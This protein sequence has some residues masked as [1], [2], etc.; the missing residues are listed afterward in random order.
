MKKHQVIVVVGDT[1]S[2]KTTQLP[3]MALEYVATLPENQRRLVGCTQPRRIAAAS[4]AKRVAE[5]LHVE[6]GDEVGYQVRFEDKSS[7]STQLKFMTD[8]ILLAETQRDREL[9]HYS[10]LIID[11]A[12]ERSLN[13]DF[14]LGYLNRLVEIRPDLRVLISSATLD[15]GAFADFFNGAPVIE[16]EGRTFPVETHY[17][18]PVRQNMELPQQVVEACEWIKS[19]DNEGDVLVFLP[20]EREIRESAEVLE[21]MRWGRTEVLPLYARLSLQQQQ[22]VFRTLNGT[23]RIVLATNVAETSLTIP[24]IVY[25]IDSGLA[26]VS[27]WNPSRQVQRLQIEPVSQASAR[28]RKGRCGRLKEG[29]CVRLYEEEDHDGRVEYTDPE[30][31]RSSLAGVIL[32]M[33]SLKLPKI[34]EFPFLDPPSSKHVSEGYRTLREI[35]ALSEDHKLTEVGRNLSRLPTEPR[36]GKMLLEASQFG[37]LAE[38]LVIVSGLSIMDPRERPQGKEPQA[39]Q[40]QAKWKHKD[41]D[42]LSLLLLWLSINQCRQGKHLQ[43]NQLRKVCKAGFLNF[44]RVIEWDNLL[45]ELTRLCKGALKLELKPLADNFESFTHPDTIHKAI[46]SGIP[47][48]VG[49]YD[50][51]KRSYRGAQGRE[52]SIFPGSHLFSKKKLEWVL[53]YE[54]VETSRLWSRRNA[55][56]NPE[57]VEEV[58][59][60][61]CKKRW[62]SAYYDEAQ[63]AVY[64]RE[65][66]SLGNLPLVENR[67]VHFG[68][69][70]EKASLEIFIREAILLDKLKSKPPIIKHLQF[71]REQVEGLE[72]K[73]RRVDG[74]WSDELLV[75]WF[76][77]HLPADC[78]TAKKFITWA[79]STQVALTL[80]DTTYEEVEN[81]HIDDFPDE[82]T[83]AD[84]CYPLYYKVAPSEVDD[85]I[86]VG[87]HV[88][89][90]SVFSNDL[91]EWGVQGDLVERTQLL[92]RSLPKVQRI[93]CNPARETAEQFAE[94]MRAVERKES[95]FIMLARF[96]SERT[97]QRMDADGFDPEKL[98]SS[99]KM[100]IW[101]CD[102]DGQELDFGTDIIQLKKKLAKLT[103]QR[104]EDSTSSEWNYTGLTGF[105][106]EALPVHIEKPQG[107]AYPALIDEGQ[108]V[109]V[110]VYA[111]VIEAASQH[112]RGVIRLFL[113]QHID[114]AK[115]LSKNLPLSIEAK[116]YLPLLGEGGVDQTA[117]LRWVIEHAMGENLARTAEDFSKAADRARG[118]LFD[119]AGKVCRLL[120][121]IVSLQR[122]V[123]SILVG[124]RHD[125]NLAEIAEDIDEQI[126]WILRSGFSRQ[127]NV[128]QLHSYKIWFEGMLQRIGRATSQALIKDLEKM[129]LILEFWSPWYERWLERKSDYPLIELGRMMNH[130]RT[131]VF[132]PAIKLPE[133]ISQKV[134]RQR[135]EELGLM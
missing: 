40:A 32:R 54:I 71:L 48:Q 111:C 134:V 23:Q 53:A 45:S 113:L 107:F 100:K 21:G 57:W 103:K 17:L 36:M 94:G 76:H 98:P 63:G 47:K 26:R 64:A 4:V 31:R 133:K 117:V 128:W 131:S 46:L 77:K 33:K 119:S 89:Q 120:D 41:S 61:L 123:E 15:S 135:M 105:D 27:R 104:F 124:W 58:A 18:P 74:I 95:I 92:I 70:N 127:I 16:V 25:V 6:M 37:C 80:Q 44:R 51:E 84:Q 43:K 7:K 49:V 106:C 8:G 79:D 108:T 38:I 14:L 88:D 10:V 86:T 5:E 67:P 22:K 112:R 60:H 35:G 29:V 85:G 68:K 83:Y 97:G 122:D 39:E 66:V 93:A 12:H 28:Q 96:L 1:G 30:I 81:L 56:L 118:E 9:K 78:Y 132:T 116:M 19:V 82:L 42:F 102:D 130:L 13:I 110:K 75:E 52:F 121:E 73:L 126:H 55:V 3:K 72:Q 114:Q 87:V 115:H 59:P 62:H 65:V 69:I 50:R 101:V 109:G 125:K 99:L 129:D 11:E 24:G 34:E 90:L 20:G 91:L 2:G